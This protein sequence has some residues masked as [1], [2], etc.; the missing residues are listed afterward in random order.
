M[1]VRTR[2][3]PSPTGY[4]HIGGVWSALFGWLYAQHH[5][6]QFILRIEDTDTNRTIPGAMENLIESLRWFGIQWDEGPDI[7]GPYGPYIQTERQALYEKYAHWLVGHGYAYKCFATTEELEEMRANNVPGGYDRRYRDYPAERV[8]ELE[9]EGKPYVIRYKMPLDGAT[10]VPDLLRGDVVFQND[11]FTD[12]V[13]L[14]S[15]GL[16]TYH[17][18]HVVDDHFMQISHITRGV[19]WLNTAPIHVNLFQAFGWDMP[20]FVHLPVILN[21]SGKGKLSKRHQAFMDSGEKVLVRADEFMHG[22][23]LPEAVV[24]FLANVGWTFGENQEKFTMA[25][26][27]ARF[28]LQNVSAAPTKLPYSKLDW[29][30]GLYIQE[31]DNLALAQ[32]LKPYLEAE[33]W[34]VNVDSLLLV[35]DAMKPRMK[36]FPDAIPFL[37]FLFDETPLSA[38]VDDLTDKKLPLPAAI[39]AYEESRDFLTAVSPFDVPTIGSGLTE[40]GAKHSTTEKAGPFLG[41][42][43]FA[44]TGQQVSPPV[45]ESIVAM[46]RPRVLARLEEIL[47]I[48]QTAV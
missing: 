9:A 38:T 37:R 43:R 3:A 20:V 22:G 5:Q 8:A 7:G 11:Q 29:L 24:N 10:I 26:A 34:E 2:F 17:L 33:G 28:D 36:I 12:Y 14:K 6:G 39:A 48:L 47:A 13:L 30:N 35:V 23:Y 40:I 42:L 27:I 16:P 15:N 46:G 44:I 31:M 18:A 41:K 45:F 1:T 25:E 19:E 32:T 4:L 21:P